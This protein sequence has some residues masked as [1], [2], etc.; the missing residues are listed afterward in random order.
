MRVNGRPLRL[1]F[2]STGS[3]QLRSDRMLQALG[4]AGTVSYAVIRSPL[5]PNPLLAVSR[6]DLDRAVA[7]IGPEAALDSLP[8]MPGALE[9]TR[10]VNSGTR[11]AVRLVHGAG[12]PDAAEDFYHRQL[13]GQGWRAAG[14]ERLNRAG[15]A[16]RIYQRGRLVCVLAVR[17][18]NGSSVVALLA[19]E[20]PGGV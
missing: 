13:T 16:A 9:G 7:P 5:L 18:S 14:S 12:D 8:L 17:Y 10:V 3:N 2:Y 1:S 20:F 6:P 15:A 19:K 11:T 4:P